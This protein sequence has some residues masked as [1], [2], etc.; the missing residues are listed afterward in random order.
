M[1]GFVKIHVGFNCN[2]AIIRSHLFS[3]VCR[4]RETREPS[5]DW[6]SRRKANRSGWWTARDCCPPFLPPPPCVIGPAP[7]LPIFSSTFK[8]LCVRAHASHPRLPPCPLPNIVL[9]ISFFS[10]CVSASCTGSG[11]GLDAH[12][13]SVGGIAYLVIT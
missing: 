6:M 2:P 5:C 10:L 11:K 1:G 8:L 12:V 4:P 3:P 7:A 13:T 9:G